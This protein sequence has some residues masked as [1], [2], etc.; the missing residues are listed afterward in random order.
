MKFETAANNKIMIKKIAF[1]SILIIIII[2]ISFSCK[3]IY[4]PAYSQIVINEL[5]PV[6]SATVTDNYGQFDDWIEL[7]NLSGSAT[8]LSGYYLSDSKN[9]LSKWQ[10]PE[11]TIIQGGGYL[12]IWADKDTTQMGLHTN[13]KLSS[14]GENVVLSKPD[15]TI[16]DK[17]SYPAQTLELSYSRVPNGTGS[18][19]WQPPTNNKSNDSKN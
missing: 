8:D 11:G 16:I 12:I 10:I 19:K 17:V 7:Y 13:F 9:N 18:F 3:K 1:S 6:N 15:L 2:I 5:M 4:D 14:S